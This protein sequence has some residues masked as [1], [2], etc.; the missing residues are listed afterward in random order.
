MELRQVNQAGRND[1]TGQLKDSGKS[2]FLAWAGSSG[3]CGC[4]PPGAAN[5]V[6]TQFSQ[7]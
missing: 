4:H 1:M 3:Q 7:T 6:A 2:V 5:F